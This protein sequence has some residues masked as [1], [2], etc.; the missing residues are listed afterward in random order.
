MKLR[1]LSINGQARA[2]RRRTEG[3]CRPA[4]KYDANSVIKF[5]DSKD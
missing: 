2:R 5:G 3:D 4:C 1:F